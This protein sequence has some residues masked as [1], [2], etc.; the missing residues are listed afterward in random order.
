VTHIS[1]DT[2]AQGD[3]PGSISAD[4][5]V[6]VTF[7]DGSAPGYAEEYM[8]VMGRPPIPCQVRSLGELRYALRSIHR[9]VPWARSV[10][11]AVKDPGQVP[12]W[13]NRDR[14]R[15]AYHEDFL[16]PETRPCFN[17]FAIQAWAFRIPG[18]AKNFLLWFDDN[19]V[20]AP[21]TRSDFL[22]DGG[23]PRVPMFAARPYRISE[24]TSRFAVR[25]DNGFRA[26]EEV[27]RRKGL[28]T[29]DRY[30]FVSHFANAIDSD[31]WEGFLN[32]FMSFPGFEATVRSPIR[33]GPEERAV[34]MTV[35]EL[36]SAWLWAMKPDVYDPLPGRIK[37]GVQ[38][39]LERLRLRRSSL[40]FYPI[41][42]DPGWNRKQMIRMSRSRP[43]FAN[44]NDEA[45]HPYED[46]EGKIWVNQFELEPHAQ[47]E[48]LAGMDCLFPEP[49]PFE[50]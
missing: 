4:V 18:L 6:V 7:V 50:I 36:W 20:L 41:R 1:T 2:A 27:L 32:D 42:H 13:L 12:P 30:P 26:L 25:V 40:G 17:T 11:L 43:W 48:L 39:F 31:L 37:S 29:S 10:F 14:V 38:K 9:Y 33:D 35:M 34:R 45:Y 28:P 16:P 21:T 47:A 22:L 15:I 44:V 49:S 24:R 19:L 3:D 23:R 5:D 8:E 46:A